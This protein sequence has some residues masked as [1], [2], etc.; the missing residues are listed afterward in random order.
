[1]G[2]KRYENHCSG[3]IQVAGWFSDTDNLSASDNCSIV[4]KVEIGRTIQYKDYQRV[5][6]WISNISKAENSLRYSVI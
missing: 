1:M 6:D 4:S 5:F 2:Q 3:K